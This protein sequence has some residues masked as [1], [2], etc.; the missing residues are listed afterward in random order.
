MKCYP[1]TLGRCGQCNGT[2]NLSAYAKKFL[3]YG[4]NGACSCDHDEEVKGEDEVLGPM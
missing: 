2:L 1:C 3:S 4:N